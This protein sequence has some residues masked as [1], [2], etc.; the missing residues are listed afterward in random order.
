MLVHRLRRWT[1]I[2]QTLVQRLLLTAS[3]FL[4]HARGSFPVDTLK[5]SLLDPQA[6]I[7]RSGI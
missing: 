4:L 6:V 1:N 3:P 7:I 5:R 2:K